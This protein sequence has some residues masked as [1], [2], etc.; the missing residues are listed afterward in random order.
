[1]FNLLPKWLYDEISSCY[2]YDYLTEIRIRQ[3]KPIVVC[4]K[5]NYEILSK[6]NCYSNQNITASGDLISY[7]ITVATKQ[8]FYAYNN[9]IKQCFLTTDNGI[10][11]GVCGNVVMNNGEVSTI[12]NITS[13]NIRIPHSIKNCSKNII[14]LICQN[15]EVK[16]TLIISPP[17][18][19]KTTLVRDVAEKL[20]NEKNINNILVID[21]RFEICGLDKDDKLFSGKFVDVISGSQK[22]FAFNECIKTM[23]PS[24]II[25]DEIFDSKDIMSLSQ[26]AMCGV[27]VIATA[28]AEGLEDLK[29]KENF[30]KL[31]DDKVFQRIVILSKKR[32]IGIVD[33]VFDENLK[34]IYFP[35]KI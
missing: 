1:M 32:G 33:S 23:N 15:Y 31:I 14:N 10:R 35:F 18:A 8:S 25:T 34:L 22:S 6:K 2:I 28:H 9:Q 19:G 27:K 5:G 26:I 11:I 13:L 12:K 20:S 4:Y 30:K 17:G 16:N 7:I 21:E 3:N 24:V 29:H